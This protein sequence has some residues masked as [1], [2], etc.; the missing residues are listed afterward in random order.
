MRRQHS[1]SLSQTCL[2]GVSASAGFL[3]NA[4]S[5]ASAGFSSPFGIST[6][7]GVSASAS[8]SSAQVTSRRTSACRMRQ[9]VAHAPLHNKRW[10]MHVFTYI[11]SGGHRHIHN[12]RWSPLKNQGHLLPP[13]VSS[14]ASPVSSWSVGWICISASSAASS[15][16]KS[17]STAAPAWD[18]PSGSVAG[19]AFNLALSVA[20]RRARS[21]Q[22]SK[23]ELD[24]AIRS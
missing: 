3:P 17:S 15:A 18:C 23:D 12:K 8:F 10:H 24:D 14:R 5:S 11:T 22:G 1:S 16:R 2:L 7:A 9:A 6:F 21:K 13:A 4:G 20:K 19:A